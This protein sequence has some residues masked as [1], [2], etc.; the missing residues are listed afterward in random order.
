MLLDSATGTPVVPNGSLGF[1]YTESGVGKWNLDLEGVTPALSVRDARRG[2]SGVAEVLLP[3][4]EAADGTGTVL[5]RGV[6]TRRMGE[7]LVTTVY[8]LML[9]QYGVERDGLPGQWPTGYDDAETPY[10]PAWQE[11]ITSVPAQAATRIAREFATQRRAVRRPLHDHHGGRD[12]P[13]V[14]RRRDVPRRARDA[15]AH[16]L[17]GRNG[18]G[19]AHYVGQEKC[20]PITGWVSLANGAGLEPAAAYD[21]R[22]PSYWYM[23]TD[24]WRFDG[25]QAD[26]LA[27]PLAEGHLAGMHTADTIAQSARLG[28]MPFYPQFDRNPLDLADE[29]IAANPDAPIDHVVEEL[30]EGNLKFAVDD[31]DAPG[32]LAAHARA[33]A[34]EPAGVLRQGQR[35]LPEVPARHPL[36]RGGRPS[37]GPEVMRP[38][39]VTWRDDIPEGKLDL[40][41]SADFRMTSTT[42]LSDVIFPAAT[43]Y[44]KHDLSTTDMHPFIHAFTPAIDPPW[45]AKSDFDTFHADRAQAL[46]AWPRPTSAPARTWS[47]CPCCTTPPGDGA[48]RRASPATGPAARSRRIPGRPCPLCRSSSATT[49]PSRT[50]SARSVRSP[51]RWAS[52]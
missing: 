46:G 50:S 1:R 33:V 20:R 24:Q 23:H 47:A 26:A 15:H 13:V 39:D 32:E 22:G 17:M 28:W 42:L 16:R 11:T 48:A 29:A 52:P 27:S 43:W 5:R 9:A 36:Q 41:V 7:H 6:P 38:S 19:W 2:D 18:G 44:E 35:V 51:R 37:R 4:F 12:L 45:E 49:P 40:L 3:C 8:D 34:R 25:Y 10:T 30:T 14:P 21:D 31:V